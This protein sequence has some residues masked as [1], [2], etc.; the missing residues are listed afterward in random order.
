MVTKKSKRLRWMVL[1]VM[2]MASSNIR[3]QTPGAKIKAGISSPLKI[4]FPLKSGWEFRQAH[5]SEWYPAAIPGYVQLDLMNNKLIDDPFFRD[6]EY[7]LQWVGKADW[8]YRTIFTAE[9]QLFK[10]Q[11]IDI[12]FEGLDTYADVFVNDELVLRA[13]NMFRTWRVD[14]KTLLRPG[15]N[16]LRVIFRSPI[17]EVLPLMA[18]I[19]Y[20][21]PAPNDQGEKTS[22]Y[23]RKAPYQFGWDWGPRLVTSGIWKPILLE[24]WDDARIEDLH[25]VQEEIKDKIAQ[26]RAELEITVSKNLSA[27]I[28]IED[29]TSRALHTKDVNLNAGSNTVSLGFAIN[30]PKRWWPNGMGAQP[31][32]KFRAR[33]RSGEGLLDQSVVRI[34]LR[35]LELRQQVDSWGKSFA[36][37]VNGVPTFARGANWIPADSFPTRL[38]KTRYQNL[39]KS[40]H[41]AN[42]NMLRVWGG[43][44]YESD[45]FYDLCDEM[46]I[47]VWQ[48]F[49]FA[50][51]MYPGNQE[52]LANVRQEATENVK[53]LRNH[54]SLAIWVGNNEIE[55]AWTHWGW[56]KQFP[57]SL[58]DDYKKIF[59]DLLPGVCATLDPSRPYWP[60]S[61]SSNLEAD[62]D[63]PET[64][65]VHYW[66]VWHGALPF[67]EYEKQLP[68]FMSEFGFQSF[69]ELK[70]VS[71]YTLVEDRDIESE[72]MLS[73]QKHPR[74][75]QLIREYMLRDFGTPKDFDSFLYVSQLLQAEGIRVGAEHLRRIMPRNM[76]SL[77][78]Q[79]DDC[80]PGASWS[81]I[82]YFGRWKALQYYAR[83]FYA[84]VLISP[85][86]EQDKINIYVVSDQ[87][88]ALPATLTVSLVDFAGQTIRRFETQARIEPLTSK[89]YSSLPRADLLGK[90]DPKKVFLLCELTAGGKTVS[91]N[92]MFFVPPKKQSLTVPEIVPQIS[93]APGGYLITLTTNTL[94]RNTF[95]SLDKS[96]GFFSDN[97]FDLIPGRPVSVLL[98]LRAP[99]TRNSL[100]QELKIRSLADAIDWSAR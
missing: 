38:D 61:P 75:N 49:M 84:N 43:G 96:D 66:G 97:F 70:T 14:C 45:D 54:P 57:L 92:R 25:I 27:T 37:F 18:K 40:S 12:V 33:L 94:A 78:W 4:S 90:E 47:L 29:E 89:I 26:L 34:G 5:G 32:Y 99:I 77:F 100:L 20:Q 42:M 87:R 60:S 64:G 72:V 23:T 28:S 7:Q 51:S 41:D 19:P 2:V 58:W 63:S 11:H 85:H 30:N 81:S 67:S 95:L 46:G 91:S 1:V 10:R 44:I 35:T 21:L 65:D 31:L 88:E 68:R 22:P 53:R 3:S 80:W 71:T 6:N 9:P 73:H 17:R 79:L 13:N 98:K 8:E 39:I 16:G 56:N 76:G 69:P 50:G 74:G 86:E 24:A 82:D 48:D 15:E 52:F 93:R 59:H 55:S 62:S 36:F 83:R